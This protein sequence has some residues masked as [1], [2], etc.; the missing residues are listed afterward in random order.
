MAR[1]TYCFSSNVNS[2]FEVAREKG[3]RCGYANAGTFFYSN[4][5]VSASNPDHLSYS[6]GCWRQLQR[7]II[8]TLGLLI[9]D[10]G[11]K[12]EMQYV[13]CLAGKRC[14][15]CLSRESASWGSSSPSPHPSVF[16]RCLTSHIMTHHWL[17]RTCRKSIGIN[18]GTKSFINDDVP[19]AASISHLTNVLYAAAKS[20][21]FGGWLPLTS[22]TMRINGGLPQLSRMAHPIN[23]RT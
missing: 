22:A 11:Q 5:P 19:C 17:A 23:R 4:T 13:E 9:T 16:M 14:A 21:Q 8:R 7:K 10:K 15:S 18:G 1:T 20:C 2:W 3:C 12:V 6:E